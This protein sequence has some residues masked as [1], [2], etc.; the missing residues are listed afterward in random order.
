MSF[1]KKTLSLL[2]ISLLALSLVA[3][4]EDPVSTDST[5]G[6][7]N[8]TSGSATDASSADTDSD[9]AATDSDGTPAEPVPNLVMACDQYQKRIVIY[10]LELLEPGDDLDLAEVWS[11]DAGYCADMKYREDTVFGDVVVTAGTTASIIAYPSKEIVW[12]TGQPGSNPHAVEILPN[13]DLC[14]ANSSGSCIRYFNTGALAESKDA[15][16][17]YTDY[18]LKDAHGVLWDPEYDCLWAVGADELIAFTH[19]GTGLVKLAGAGGTL[20]K[21]NEGGHDLSADM[22]NPRY[23]YYT[24][25]K[26]AVRYD[27]EEEE[28]NTSYPNRDKLSHG[29]QKGFSNNE[30]NHYFYILC[31]G[32]GNENKPWGNLNIAS[33]CSDTLYYGTWKNNGRLLSIQEYTSSTSAFYK[34]RAFSGKYQ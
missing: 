33:W 2:L 1:W 32:K 10:D 31:N 13:G 11:V 19:T 17:R 30:N 15:K 18:P 27:K 29:Y 26:G 14:I 3:C 34:T 25:H 7:G 22:T 6:T 28:F 4:G 24:G 23:L 20:P 16:V 12:S 21:D 5:P 9:P 8:E